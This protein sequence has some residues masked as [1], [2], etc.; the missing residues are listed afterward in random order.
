M[1]DERL[2]VADSNELSQV[3]LGCSDVDV[4]VAVVVEDAEFVRKVQVD[5]RRLNVAVAVGLDTD[6]A[7]VEGRADVSV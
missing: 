7:L 6:A 2:L 1:K 3:R 5:R 4:R